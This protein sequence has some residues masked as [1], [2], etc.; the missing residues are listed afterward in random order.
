MGSGKPLYDATAGATILFHRAG[1]SALPKDRIANERGH[2]GTD[3]DP[4][5]G[6]VHVLSRVR[7]FGCGLHVFW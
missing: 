3:L 4:G 6:F 2:P 7:L 5:A 1:S